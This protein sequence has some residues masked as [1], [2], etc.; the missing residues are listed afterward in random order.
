MIINSNLGK[1]VEHDM[2][3]NIPGLVMPI[4]QENRT[5]KF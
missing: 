5:L 4:I 3:I 1:S 2:Q